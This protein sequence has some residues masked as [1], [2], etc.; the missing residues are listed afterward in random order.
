MSNSHKGNEVGRPP[1]IT[2]SVVRKLEKA[3]MAGLSD[4]QACAS[5]GI[6]RQTLY[7]YCKD[8]PEFSDR[9]EDLK[10]MP[11]IHAQIAIAKAVKTDPN[12]A[13]KYL[14][15]KERKEWAPP[16][17]KQDINVTNELEHKSEEQLDAEL[18]AIQAELTRREAEWGLLEEKASCPA[19]RPQ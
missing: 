19:S 17:V 5:V 11:A 9:K 1:V 10:K 18:D 15:R 16:T 12:M 13:L 4:R 8:N 14:E 2:E 7:D 6:G 3:F